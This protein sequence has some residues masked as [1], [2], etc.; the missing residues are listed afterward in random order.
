MS[1]NNKE[2]ISS[3]KSNFLN[4]LFNLQRNEHLNNYACY[5][6]GFCQIDHN[7]YRWCKG[8][9]GE[10]QSQFKTLSYVSHLKSGSTKTY[11][12]DKC[13]KHFFSND[14]LK[15]HK[16]DNHKNANLITCKHCQNTFIEKL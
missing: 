7:R 13:Q 1:V 14:D 5:C 4:K 3:Q 16:K 15:L 8:V 9:S 12:C 10:L 2:F 6:K 11:S